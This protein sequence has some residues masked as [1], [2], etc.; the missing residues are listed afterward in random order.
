LPQF[1]ADV[2]TIIVEIESD[3]DGCI[4]TLTHEGLRPG[5]EQSTISG[6]GKMFDALAKALR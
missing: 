5:Y 2:D 6:W 1:A 3:G 4:L